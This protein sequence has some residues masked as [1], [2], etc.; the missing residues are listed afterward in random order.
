MSRVG[1]YQKGSECGC[2]EEFYHR[3]GGIQESHH[4]G[5]VSAVKLGQGGSKDARRLKGRAGEGEES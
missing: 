2:L 4:H 3:A 5:V 1:L